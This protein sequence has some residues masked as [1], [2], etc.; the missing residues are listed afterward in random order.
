ML[1]SPTELSFIYEFFVNVDREE[2][3]LYILGIDNGGKHSMDIGNHSKLQQDGDY[4]SIKI[5][6]G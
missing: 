1:L 4:N 5:Q 6:D 3:I 2:N